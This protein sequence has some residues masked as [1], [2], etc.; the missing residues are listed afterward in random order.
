MKGIP[1]FRARRLK[2]AAV[3]VGVTA[4]VAAGAALGTGTAHAAGPNPVADLGNGN[5]AVTANPTSGATNATIIWSS[6]ACPSGSQSA[7]LLL[8]DPLHPTTSTQLVAPIVNSVGTAFTFTSSGSNT[9]LGAL[10]G[11]ADDPSG[12]IAE[13]V[14]ECF[15]QTSGNGTGTFTD[16]DFLQFDAT[17]ANYTQV[18]NPGV[19]AAPTPVNVTLTGPASA[20]VGSSVNLTASVSPSTATGSVTFSITGGSTLG[21][22]A[23]SGGVASLPFSFATAVP[24]PGVSL[25]ATYVPP[26]PNPHNFTVGTAGTGSVVVNPAP[27]NSGNIPLAVLVPQFGTFTLTVDTTDWVTLTVTNPANQAPTDATGVTTAITATDT[28]NTFPGW[29]VSGQSTPFLGAIPAAPPGYPI[30]APAGTPADHATQQFAADNLGWTPT[31][32]IGAVTLGTTAV[33]GSN[34]VF[35]GAAIAKGGHL[36]DAAQPLATAP[37]GPSGNGVGTY[38]LGANLDLNIPVGQEAGPYAS[39]LDITSVNHNP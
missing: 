13:V 30:T 35:L 29:S 24:S 33:A 37:G 5:A 6:P 23:I 36:G 14:V 1:T 28:R 3:L 12:G 10:A 16:D 25:T 32:S 31:G 2:Q 20:T 4:L 19:V 17:S 11:L 9:V 22:A 38:T 18:P 8:A 27:A 26:T 15:T 39:F 21:T 7:K 34:G